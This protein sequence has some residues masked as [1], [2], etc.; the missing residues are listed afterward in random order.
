MIDRARDSQSARSRPLTLLLLVSCSCLS[1]LAALFPFSLFPFSQRG[2]ARQVEWRWLRLEMMHDAPKSPTGH[3]TRSFSGVR[4]Q[5]CW[6]LTSPSRP[7]RYHFYFFFHFIR[8]DS[9]FATTTRSSCLFSAHRRLIQEERG[10]CTVAH[11][12]QAW[13]TIIYGSRDDVLPSL[14]WSGQ[15]VTGRTWNSWI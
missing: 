4:I 2:P 13:S 6:N 9:L 3:K 12:R 5:E 8:F 7:T 15:W 11:P 14:L 1:S 10:R